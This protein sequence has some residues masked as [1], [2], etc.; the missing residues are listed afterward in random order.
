MFAFPLICVLYV[1]FLGILQWAGVKVNPVSYVTLVMAIG[2]LV[3]YL[4]H[5]LL[6]YY[7]TPGNREEKVI[8]VLRSMGSSVMMGGITTFLGTVPLAF[9]ASEIFTTVF[10]A[11]ITLV[12]LGISH[13]L[14]LLP[15]ILSIFGPE[16]TIYMGSMSETERSHSF[17][18]IE[19][20]KTGEGTCNNVS[21]DD[22]EEDDEMYA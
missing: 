17:N 3:D 2:L 7:K 10:I 6:H 21:V 4:L 14:I 19:N 18:D 8:A 15:V 1:D 16:D 22:E 20:R 12:V 13:G 9:S 5:V 11:F